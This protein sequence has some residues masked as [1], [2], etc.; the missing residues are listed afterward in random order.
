MKNTSSINKKVK[1]LKRA[2]FFGAL[3]IFAFALPD[4]ASA[5]GEIQGGPDVISQLQERILKATQNWGSTL[6]AMARYLLVTLGVIGFIWNLLLSMLKGDFDIQVVLGEFTKLVLIVGVVYFI[7]ENIN[8]FS[9]EVILVFSKLGTMANANN[10]SFGTS[11]SDLNTSGIISQGINYFNQLDDLGDDF[12][13]KWLVQ[14][15]TYPKYQEGWGVGPIAYYFDKL[16][17]QFFIGV[18]KGIGIFLAICYFV[19][20][21]AVFT[22]YVEIYVV[23]GVGVILLGFLSNSITAETGKKYLVY[24]ISAAMKLLVIFL[25]IGLGKE[26]ID[27]LFNE[28][29]NMTSNDITQIEMSPTNVKLSNFVWVIVITILWVYLLMKI[30]ETVASLINGVSTGGAAPFAAAA[31]GAAATI[32]AG[33][34]MVTKGI[35]AKK[36]A[37][38]A[39][40]LAR[41]QKKDGASGSVLGNAFKN[42]RA[43]GKTAKDENRKSGGKANY[44]ADDIL[45]NHKNKMVQDSL[46]KMSNHK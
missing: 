21:I 37:S 38:S 44:H 18:M 1:Y 8:L 25:I 26:M 14:A 34:G 9:H 43:A 20:S 13:D 35:M 17:W 7:I 16:S 27:P 6:S 40:E 46:K 28:I 29:F 11:P 41:M 24:L 3:V 42:Y 33:A 32:A 12:F 36:A 5:A 2:L 31:A 23:T 19:A 22:A 4:F 39:M 30:P 15:E 10:P 45:K